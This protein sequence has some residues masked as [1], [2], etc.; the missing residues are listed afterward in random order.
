MADDVRLPDNAFRPLATGER[1][2]PVV[3]AGGAG[4]GGHRPLGGAGVLLVHRLLGRRHLHRPQARPG[5]RVGHPDLDP[6]RGLLRLRGAL[7]PAARLEPAGERERAGDRR[8]VRDHRRR[9]RLHDAGRLHPGSRGAVVVLP[10][11][12]G[13]AAGRD[14]RHLLPR[15]VPPLLRARP[16]RQAA[17]PGGA[18]HHRDPGRGQARRPERDRA[19]LLGRD[20]GHLRLRR[21]RRCGAGRRT[22]PPRPSARWRRSRRR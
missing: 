16:A 2:Q 4:A 12:P 14:P 17:L 5:D 13:A 20:R 15:P 6:R 8:H 3:P 11:L 9:L 19:H 7:P 10:D 21:A 1:Y 18:G 22:S